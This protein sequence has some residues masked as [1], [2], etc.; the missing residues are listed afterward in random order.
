MSRMWTIALLTLLCVTLCS[1]SA[2]KT[3]ENSVVIAPLYAQYTLDGADEFARQAKELKERIG[4]GPGAL[5]GFASFVR[6][7][8]PD[9]D[10]NQQLREESLKPTLGEVDLVVDR[11]RE[12]GLVAHISLMTGFFHGSN[13]LRRNAILQAVRNAQWFSDGWISEPAALTDPSNVP[14]SV[15]ITPSRYAKPLRSRMEEGIRMLGAHL[16]KRMAEHPETLVT[17][18]GD[19]EVEFSFERNIESGERRLARD[20]AVY[21]DYSPFMVEEFRDWLRNRSYPGDLS[22][23]TDENRDGRTFNRDFKLSLT[24]WKLRYYDSSGPIPFETYVA[25]KDK[26]PS[27]GKFA[28]PGGFDAPRIEKPGDPFWEEWQ[29]FRRQVIANYVRDFA[30]WITSSP[31]PT[32]GKSLP[33]SHF[34]SHQ[35]PGD[36]LFGQKENLR[37]KTSASYADTA[38]IAPYGSTGVTVFNIFDG[39]KH[40]RTAT[41]DLFA[42]LSSKGRDWGILEYNPSVPV[43]PTGSPSADVSF[44]LEELRTVGRFR[45]HLLVPFAWSEDPSLKQYKIKGS[46]F[47]AALKQFVREIRFP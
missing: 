25:L 43:V 30:Q 40:S 36:Y 18:S 8:F 29:K 19:G 20:Q 17:V 6:M 14:A 27:T 5:L 10:L 32:T 22:P 34:Y 16:A 3:Y 28:T 45:P 11:A 4:E 42:F 12:N 46:A 39:T 33:P 15:W 9:A 24:T 44:Y 47:E 31:D 21:A 7:E 23:A 13:T 1:Q 37:L 41:P 2:P 38:F 26:L 35:I